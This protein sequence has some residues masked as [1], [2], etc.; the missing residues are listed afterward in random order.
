MKTESEVLKIKLLPDLYSITLVAMVNE[1]T[2]LDQKRLL[3]DQ[4]FQIVQFF[5]NET[6]LRKAVESGS[7]AKIADS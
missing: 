2:G 4:A 5:D 6:M 3:L 1:R 7:W